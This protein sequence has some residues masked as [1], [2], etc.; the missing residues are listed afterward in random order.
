MECNN[1]IT[2]KSGAVAVGAVRWVSRRCSWAMAQWSCRWR[3][4]RV[5]ATTAG[6]FGHTPPLKIPTDYNRQINIVTKLQDREDL[7]VK[8]FAGLKLFVLFNFWPCR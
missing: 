4:D 8:N 7:K 1:D 5:P 2:G 6:D 3:C